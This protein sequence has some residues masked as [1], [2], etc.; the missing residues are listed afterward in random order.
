MRPH[1]IAVAPL[2]LAVA[3]AAP[4]VAGQGRRRVPTC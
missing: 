2:V 3:V 1:R 4:I